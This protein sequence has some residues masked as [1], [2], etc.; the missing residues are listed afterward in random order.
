M[1]APQPL[2]SRADVARILGV[3]P[4]TVSRMFADGRLPYVRVSYR[5]VGVHPDALTRFIEDN[6]HA[7]PQRR[8]RAV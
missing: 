4:R 2:V 7:A 8:L 1:T 3:S 5:V 6:T